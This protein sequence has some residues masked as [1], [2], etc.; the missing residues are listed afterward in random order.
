MTRATDPRDLEADVAAMLRRRA[1]DVAGPP[2]PLR[3]ADEV[4]VR[5]LPAR[6]PRSRRGSL[7]AAAAAL[8]VAATGLALAASGD[9]SPERAP[10]HRVE[11]TAPRSVDA[12]PSLPAGWDPATAPRIHR[13]ERATDPVAVARTYL[14][15][16][17]S[18]GARPN[19]PPARVRVRSLRTGAYPQVAWSYGDGSRSR[20]VVHLRTG[21]HG[22]DIVA[23]TMPGVSLH[24]VA[25]H[26]DTVAG[27]IRVRGRF[28]GRLLVGVEPFGEA[29][30]ELPL[31]SPGSPPYQRVRT[32]E[33]RWT[34]PVGGARSVVSARFVAGDHLVGLAQVRVDPP[35]GGGVD[36]SSMTPA[37]RQA[38]FEGQTPEICKVLDR[39][40]PVDGPSA[41]TGPSQLRLPAGPP[42]S[43]PEAPSPARAVAAFA[44]AVDAPLTDGVWVPVDRDSG[45]WA[46]RVPGSH[47]FTVLVARNPQT[48]RW[49]VAS[50]ATS[51]SCDVRGIGG[52]SA[53][54]GQARNTF[55]RIPG[56]SGGV[57][58]YRTRDGEAHAV[59]LSAVAAHD[60]AITVDADRRQV[61]RYTVVLVDLDHTVVLVEMTAL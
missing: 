26:D 16:V 4:D 52:S 9:R 37:E 41:P 60:G 20:G 19:S 25:A 23:L 47:L 49:R 29:L 14:A 6:G 56:A 59:A 32:N 43:P 3:P 33:D 58:W 45:S 24:D 18:N 53:T 51:D 21:R 44:T 28:P 7:V 55:S 1:A 15:Q 35:E 42:V 36:L 34:V 13:V 8:V 38:F 12:E 27:R 57:L 2:P 61:T 5:A 17:F 48:G 31:I 30:A 22:I 39:E 10:K 46:V 50:A 11:T 54:P 40:H